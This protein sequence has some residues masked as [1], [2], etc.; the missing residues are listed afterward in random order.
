MSQT[1]NERIY[2]RR[3]EERKRTGWEDEGEFF[4]GG[5]GD[6]RIGIFFRMV[7]LSAFF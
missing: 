7:G 2:S 1:M 3:K 6:V 5:W 4:S